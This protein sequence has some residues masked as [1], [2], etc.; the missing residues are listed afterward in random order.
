MKDM[1]LEMK[2]MRGQMEDNKDL[3]VLMAGLRGKNLSQSD[4]AEAD[5]QVSRSHAQRQRC[6]L[7]SPCIRCAWSAE[8]AMRWIASPHRL[9]ARTPR[10]RDSTLQMQ[11]LEM[12][13]GVGE[14]QLPQVYSPAGI[15]QYWGRRPVA[16]LRRITQLLSECA[17]ARSVWVGPVC[18]V[19]VLPSVRPAMLQ[20][21]LSLILLHARPCASHACLV[22][23]P[24]SRP[25][26]Q[27]PRHTPT[28]IGA[29]FLFSLGRDALAGTLRDNAV[30]HAIRLRGILTSLGP[31][32][33]KL[34]QALSIRP[35]V[36]PP[37][38]MVEMQ[39]LCDK[40]PSFDSGI[41]MA[42]LSSELGKPWTE[43]YAELTAEPVAAAS[44]GQVGPPLVQAAACWSVGVRG[45]GLLCRRSVVL[46]QVPTLR[47]CCKIL[48]REVPTQPPHLPFSC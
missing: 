20:G 27:P 12:V 11:L 31:A 39:K 36:L 18:W 34:G 24:R 13:D 14:E 41:A 46:P 10:S 6:A 42:M 47:Y 4:F 23:D 22:I 3:A 32:Y 30:V 44:L 7:R 48:P 25:P 21:A 1:A 33:I 28:A 45:S 35:D 9:P 16:V 40:V 5:V 26:T 29:G 19:D 43:V 8:Q 38:A 15:R 37:A 17:A 2:R